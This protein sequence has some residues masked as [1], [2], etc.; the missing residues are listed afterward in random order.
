MGFGTSGFELQKMLME[1]IW[2][3]SGRSNEEIEL[4][5]LLFD[6]KVSQYYE[7]KN[8]YEARQNYLYLLANGY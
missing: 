1:N 5:K 2:Y 8:T 7:K 3:L 4:K 6:I